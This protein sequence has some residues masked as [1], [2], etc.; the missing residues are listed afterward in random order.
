MA[1]GRSDSERRFRIWLNKQYS[2]AFIIKMPDMKQT[3]LT[4]GSGLPDYLAVKDGR[5]FWWEVKLVPSDRVFPFSAL[6]ESQWI[7]FKQMTEAGA[8]VQIACYTA[9][10]ERHDFDFVRLLEKYG[11]GTSVAFQDLK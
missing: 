1:T 9:S 10:G 3:G 6:S 7:K 4:H 8:L 11:S 2:P 5:H